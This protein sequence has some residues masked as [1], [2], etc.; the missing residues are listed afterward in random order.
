[1]SIKSGFEISSPDVVAEDFGSEIVV[2][3]L[4]NGKYFSLRGV[5]ADIW[6][7]LASGLPPQILLDHLRSLQNIHA[8]FVQS[9]VLDLIR[10]ELIRPSKASPDS[11]SPDAAQSVVALSKGAEAPILEIFDDMAE[12][13]L[14]DPIHDVDEDIGWPVKRTPPAEK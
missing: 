11:I 14:S 10:E 8:D 1:M 3:N 7:D 12:L 2:L 4:S 6:R 9:F 5:A 13:I